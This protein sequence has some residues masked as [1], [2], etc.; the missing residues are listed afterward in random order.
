LF[1]SWGQHHPRRRVR[2]NKEKSHE[3][4]ETARNQGEILLQRQGREHCFPFAVYSE[5]MQSETTAGEI[6]HDPGSEWYGKP[7]LYRMSGA[8]GL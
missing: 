8:K 5:D 2:A 1:R 3:R 7:N 4:T 6:D